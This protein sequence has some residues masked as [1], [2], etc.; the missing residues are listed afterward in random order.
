V[1]RRSLSG[2]APRINESE[3]PV[4]VAR[5]L[6]EGEVVARLPESTPPRRALR[7]GR[8]G[9]GECSNLVHFLCR[10]YYLLL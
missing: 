2:A 9:A 5:G 4:A 10:G 6:A 1:V 3:A 7:A 8:R